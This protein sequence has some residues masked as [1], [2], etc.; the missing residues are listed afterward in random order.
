MILQPRLVAKSKVVVRG[1]RNGPRVI[2]GRANFN[3]QGSVY[4]AIVHVHVDIAGK[5]LL[6]VLIP[7]AKANLVFRL[8]D[9]VP[10]AMAPA[11]CA[12]VQLVVSLVGRQGIRTPVQV[13]ARAANTIAH[14]ATNSAQIHWVARILGFILK[15]QNQGLRH[16][17]MMQG[18]HRRAYWREL[19]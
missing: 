4:Q 14:P 5:T 12:P 11:W 17:P 8:L 19:G 18:H 6:A 15:A 9:D 2:G 7:Q 3:I 13:K 16:S 1:W 10:Y